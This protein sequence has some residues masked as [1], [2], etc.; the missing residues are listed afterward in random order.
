M[1]F[2]QR[3]CHCPIMSFHVVYIVTDEEQPSTLTL[4]SVVLAAALHNSGC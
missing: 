4:V 2:I 1:L 3:W